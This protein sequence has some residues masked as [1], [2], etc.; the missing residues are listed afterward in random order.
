MTSFS[1]IVVYSFSEA[2]DA[3]HH[4]V[5]AAKLIGNKAGLIL[6]RAFILGE[7]ITLIA[8]VLQTLIISS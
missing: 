2:Q 6:P 3:L 4:D 7:H 8:V 1:N 5:L